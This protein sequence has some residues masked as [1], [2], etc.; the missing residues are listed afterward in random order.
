MLESFDEWFAVRDGHDDD[1]IWPGRLS[2]SIKNGV[3]LEAIAFP[4]GGNFY[5]AP[6][7]DTGTITGYL[8]YQRPT[9]IINPWVQSRG[10]GSMG[11]DTPVVRSKARIIGSAILKNIHLTDINE[12][13][14][15]GVSM[16]L[17]A[18]SSWYAPR[19]VKTDFS[20]PNDKGPAD[21]SVD[22]D[23]PEHSEFV[24]NDQTKVTIDSYAH[25]AT[26]GAVTSVTQRTSLW[27]QFSEAANYEA[28]I[29]RIWRVNILFS[30]L[31]G[32]RMAQSPYHLHT[33]HTRSWN[34]EDRPVVAE[35][36][37]RPTF[38]SKTEHLEWH[39]ALFTR[40]NCTLDARSIL[41]AAAEQPDALFYLMNMVLLMEHPKKLSA[42]TFSEFMGCVEDFDQTVFG[43]GSSSD[44]KALRKSLKKVVAEHGSEADKRTL[45]DLLHRSPNRYSL[46]QRVERLQR[47]WLDSGF[48]ESP[49]PIELVKL[50]NAISHGRA[51][52][53]E[54]DDYQKMVWFGYYLC[55]LSR[56]HIFRELGLPDE[57]IGEAFCRVP[58]RYGMYAPRT[59]EATNAEAETK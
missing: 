37:F 59:E 55:A 8:D 24:L 44:L 46:A 41:N 34:E 52:T 17:P 19:I 30:F 48:R 5:Q 1:R 51:V 4:D 40:H 35:L 38:K 53:L 50:R 18:F 42:N 11:V 31:L 32:H 47:A 7:C 22:V 57:D 26:E 23:R 29:K 49:D 16:D 39:D 25:P 27:F 21:V 12:R 14:F 6:N 54:V 20:F 15:T 56:F 10:G 58:Y 3:V 33:T 9:T 36:L 28:V 43:S 13:C 45:G 2:F